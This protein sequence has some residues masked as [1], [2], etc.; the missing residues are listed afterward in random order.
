MVLEFAV[1]LLV[2]FVVL[3][4]IVII[5]A[6]PLH[7]SVGL[8]GGKSSLLKAFFMTIIAQVLAAFISYRITSFNPFRFLIG[9][10][11]IIFLV[12][13]FREVFRLRWHKAVLLWIVY[14]VVSVI[15]IWLFKIILAMLA[16]SIPFLL[17]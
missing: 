12:W 7:F 10:L 14:M 4:I 6:L 16:I 8:L 17:L 2:V 5:V 13:L 3:L 15:L 9:V 11:G 1:A